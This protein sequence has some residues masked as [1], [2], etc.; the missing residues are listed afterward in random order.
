[1]IWSY[2]DSDVWQRKFQTYPADQEYSKEMLKQ[3]GW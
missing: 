1:M 3:A 2:I